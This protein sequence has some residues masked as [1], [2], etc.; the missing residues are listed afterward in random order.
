MKL[1]TVRLGYGR[2]AAAR[3]QKKHCVL[4]PYPDVGALIASGDGWRERAGAETGER[5]R[6]EEVSFAPLL[7]RPRHVVRTRVDSLPGTGGADRPTAPSF[8]VEGG[9]HLIGAQD[10]LRLPEGAGE[11]HWGAQLGVV[12]GRPTR[13][14]TAEAA[15]GHVAGYTVVNDVAPADGDG[16][17]AGDGSGRRVAVPTP[18]GPALVTTDDTPMGGR[19]LTITCVVDNRVVQKF[20]TSDL[21]FDVA[22]VVAR[23]SALV[24]LLPG[25]LITTGTRG[26]RGKDPHQALSVRQG[27]LMVT[28]IKGV[29]ELTGT[30]LPPCR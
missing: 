14:V 30:V 27:Q 28:T 15:L 17:P 24:T 9:K 23:V 22:T 11:L 21:P 5:T 18:V 4:L 12:I 20:N 16:G 2:T 3:L 8:R 13:T 6:L 29:G 26:G 7:P 1:S 19:G 10:D 25:D